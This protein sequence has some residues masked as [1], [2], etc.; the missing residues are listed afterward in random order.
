MD[1]YEQHFCNALISRNALYYSAETEAFLKGSNGINKQLQRAGEK[2]T[3]A[4]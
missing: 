3:M 2:D 4:Y 1:F